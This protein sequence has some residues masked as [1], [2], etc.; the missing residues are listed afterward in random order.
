MAQRSY[1]WTEAS[2]LR[3]WISQELSATG[4]TLQART[5]PSSGLFQ[6]TLDQVTQP[7]Q[8][9]VWSLT[10]V[11]MIQGGAVHIDH[12]YSGCANRANVEMVNDFG[13][14]NEAKY[15]INFSGSQTRLKRVM[16]ES[17]KVRGV[18]PK[19]WQPEQIAAHFLGLLAPYAY[20]YEIITLP[21]RRQ[22]WQI[23]PGDSVDLT[24]AGLP[25][26]T[27]GRGWDAEPLI[28]IGV[29]RALAPTGNEPPCVLLCL[30]APDRRTSYYSPSC[31][32]SSWTDA[33]KTLVVED[34]AYSVPGD[35]ILD[36]TQT[37][38]DIR[39]FAD[40]AFVQITQ[41]AN[42]SST[43]EIAV[44]SVNETGS[45]FVLAA[46]PTFAPVAGDF[47]TLPAWDS[48]APSEKRFVAIADAA[49][50]LG[51]NNDPAFTY[52]G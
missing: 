37:A 22:H 41:A 43:E 5:V 40:A 27:G 26:P 29:E 13:A 39:W 19:D 38:K 18:L 33:T 45:R 20:P 52:G 11:D 1:A 8:A 24:L 17:Y 48:R 6:L 30:H 14:E 34:N 46:A 42:D 3:E 15:Q 7:L 47:V 16:A 28:V 21:L 25:A 4:W 9:T 32:V 23:Q 31:R 35:W 12:V 36:P 44:V 51:T 2:N 49:G 50:E 10:S